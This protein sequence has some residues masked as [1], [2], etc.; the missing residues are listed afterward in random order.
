MYQSLKQNHEKP[1]FSHVGKN[2]RK[3]KSQLKKNCVGVVKKRR[4]LLDHR[5]QKSALS[6]E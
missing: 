3:V 5:T 4:G 2:S 1:D 6:Q